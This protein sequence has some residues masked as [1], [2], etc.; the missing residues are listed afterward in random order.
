MADLAP[1]FDLDRIAPHR[2]ETEKTLVE[3]SGLVEVQCREAKMR[4]SFM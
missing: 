4:K 1:F 3:L 2:L